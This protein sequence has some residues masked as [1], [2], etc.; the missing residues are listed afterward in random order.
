MRVIKDFSEI[1]RDDKTVLTIGTFDGVHRGHQKIIKKV[2]EISKTESLR[3]LII[4][5]YPHPRKVINPNSNIN[6]LTTQEEQAEILNQL[7]VD[8]HLKINFTRSFSEITSY[9]FIKEYIV[10]KIG[11]KKIV[12][13]HD[14]HF[15]KSREGNIDFLKSVSSEF[16]FE[17][18]E[19]PPFE[20]DSVLVSSSMIRSELKNGNILLANRM[21]GRNYFF[22]GKVVNGDGRGRTLGYPTANI[23][24]NDD[25]KLLPMLGIYAVFIFID[26]KR[27]NGLLSIGKRP[28]FYTNGNIIPEV[29]IYDFQADIYGKEVR[30]EILE[31]IR[32]EEK[33]NSSEELIKQMDSDKQNGL[34][35]FNKLNQ[36]NN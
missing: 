5:F 3:N 14:H 32:G 8:N 31:K 9:Q 24:L 15:G 17:V 6:L 11:V 13:G 19:V 26:G 28:T 18:I 30:V 34:K 23:K 29:F 10:E 2:V 7:G 33:F 35:I 36:L 1:D 27:Y 22:T 20:I 21:L 12:I 4:T 16:G 25:D